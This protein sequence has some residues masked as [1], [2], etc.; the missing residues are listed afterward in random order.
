MPPPSS[1][2]PGSRQDE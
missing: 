1:I 2:P